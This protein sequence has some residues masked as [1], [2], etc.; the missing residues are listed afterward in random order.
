MAIQ[1]V[2]PNQPP[3]TVRDP[4]K[5]PTLCRKGSAVISEKKTP[6]LCRKEET[7]P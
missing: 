4:T 3:V 5:T 7:V 1:S 6:T 2:V